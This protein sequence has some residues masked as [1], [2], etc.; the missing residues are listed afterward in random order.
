MWVEAAG[1]YLEPI[2]NPLYCSSHAFTKI[3]IVRKNMFFVLEAQQL[4]ASSVF[5]NQRT[6][7]FFDRFDSRDVLSNPG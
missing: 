3:F 7:G 4:C 6:L 1:L 2:R 5:V